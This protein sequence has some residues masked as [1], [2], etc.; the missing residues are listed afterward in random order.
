MEDGPKKRTPKEI[1]QWFVAYLAK[2][3]NAAPETIDVTIPFENFALDSVT[4]LG[5]TGD[6]EEWLGQSVDPT[7]VYDYPTIELL[8]GYLAEQVSTR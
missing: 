7:V 3:L 6:L 5:M 1:Q 2:L 8:S 4:A